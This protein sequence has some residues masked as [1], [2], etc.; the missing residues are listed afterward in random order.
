[1][2]VAVTPLLQC[3]LTL[4]LPLQQTAEICSWSNLLPLQ[5][6]SWQEH[7]V[8]YLCWSNRSAWVQA[9]LD[10]P[11]SVQCDISQKVVSKSRIN[12]FWYTENGV[13]NKP[14]LNC[15]LTFRSSSSG[16]TLLSDNLSWGNLYSLP[17]F[18]S[19]D[20]L[21]RNEFLQV[22]RQSEPESCGL[23]LPFLPVL[24]DSLG[25]VSQHSHVA[26]HFS[27]L[28]HSYTA[29]LISLE[30]MSHW[31]TILLFVLPSFMQSALVLKEN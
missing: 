4:I 14:N 23:F 29:I 19:L 2:A 3:W 28:I 10:L 7:G 30:C 15:C 9:C 16:D 26:S 11:Y 18:C 20:G 24:S 8:C 6:C 31:N 22:Q 27:V 5:L 1:M 17:C 12:P 21:S 25:D 13:E